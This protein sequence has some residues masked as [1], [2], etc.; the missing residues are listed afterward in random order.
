M[1]E[2]LNDFLTAVLFN[3]PDDVYLFAKEYFH[4]FNPTPVKDKPLVIC[5]PYGVGKKTLFREVLKEYSDLFDFCRS[6]TTRPKKPDEEHGYHYNFITDSE[7]E[8]MKSAGDFYET[9]EKW[10]SKYGTS[11]S[12]VERI[13]KENKIPLIEVDFEGASALRILSANFVFIYPPSVEEL[14][15]RLA[16]RTDIT[17]EQFKKRILEAIIEIEKANKAVLFTNRL[18]NDLLEKAHQQLKT[19][20]EALYFQ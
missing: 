7:F 9:V 1:R 5:G 15:K 17:E 3:K 11:K 13:I 14:R 6:Y 12:E 8:S 19:L 10:G 16:N 20:I 2:I 18:N 4:P